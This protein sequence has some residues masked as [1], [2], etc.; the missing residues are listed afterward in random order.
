MITGDNHL[1]VGDPL[2]PVLLAEEEMFWR[3][4]GVFTFSRAKF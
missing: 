3:W 2:L 4:L 1:G